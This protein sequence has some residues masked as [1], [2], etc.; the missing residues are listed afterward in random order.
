LVPRAK[1]RSDLK[2]RVLDVLQAEDFVAGLRELCRMTGRRVINPLFSFLLHED[3]LTRWRAVSA[4][5]AVVDTMA[6]DEPENARIVMRRLMWSLN[7][8]SGGIGWGAPEAMGEIM[9]CNERLAEEFASM[10]VSYLDEAGNFLEYEALQRGLLWGVVRLAGV[11]PLVLESAVV[12]LPKYLESRDAVLKGLAAMAAGIL[13]ADQAC[14]Q[15]ESLI[16]DET[17]IQLY[18]NDELI[19][20]SLNQLA[21]EALSRIDKQSSGSRQ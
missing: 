6:R 14:S 16:D 4:M 19:N 11:R 15:L 8:E 13:G 12:H 10:L 3:Q 1:R 9:A 20:L 7:D 21:R 18:I 5:G 17:E 2:Q